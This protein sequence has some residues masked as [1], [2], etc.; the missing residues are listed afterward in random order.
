MVPRLQ[1]LPLALFPLALSSLTPSPSLGLGSTSL[2]W[3]WRSY[4][5]DLL[6]KLHLYQSLPSGQESILRPRELLPPHRPASAA[7]GA[8]SHAGQISPWARDQAF[9]PARLLRELI[10]GSFATSA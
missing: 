2:T 3:S 1:K 4:G 6:S 5:Y 9:Q 7:S 10:K 8:F